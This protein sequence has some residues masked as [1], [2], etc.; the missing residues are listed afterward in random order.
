MKHTLGLLFGLS[1]LLGGCGEP[2]PVNTNVRY[3]HH[4]QKIDGAYLLRINDK[5]TGKEYLCPPNGGII[6]VEPTKA[7]K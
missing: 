7:E 5:Q 1:L 4:W 2:A 6:E 3:E